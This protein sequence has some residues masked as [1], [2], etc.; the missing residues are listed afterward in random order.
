MVFSSV[1]FCY[2][3]NIRLIMQK[4]M[5]GIGNIFGLGLGSA[6]PHELRL[7]R[8]FLYSG[9]SFIYDVILAEVKII[10]VCHYPSQSECCKEVQA[11]LS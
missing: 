9:L 1:K 7:F 8:Y 5:S 10:C 3:N 11:A 2:G 4:D 6:N